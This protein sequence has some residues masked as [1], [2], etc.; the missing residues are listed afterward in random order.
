SIAWT[1][2]PLWLGPALAAVI[3]L[4]FALSPRIASP[5]RAIALGSVVAAGVVVPWLLERV[6]A[7]RSTLTV[8]ARG[9]WFH[10]PGL[11]RVEDWMVVLLTVSLVA[12]A[13]AV[14]FGV[15]CSGRRSRRQLQIQA[16]QL[17]QLVHE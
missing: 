5:R 3:A 14:G 13:V 4:I 1:F 8:D 9:V 16:W 2:A 11:E 10:A 17:R 15:A 6:G 12:T 7:I